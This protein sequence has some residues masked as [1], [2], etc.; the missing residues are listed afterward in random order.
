MSRQ[1]DEVLLKAHE[2]T[3]GQRREEYNHPFD[4]YSRVVDI[5][6]AFSGVELTPAQGAMFMVSVKLARLQNN[7]RKNLLHVDSVIDAAGYL[8]CYAQ[9]AEKMEHMTA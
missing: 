2:L 1:I 8:W 6:R 9:I 3:H 5:F 4:D 7:Y